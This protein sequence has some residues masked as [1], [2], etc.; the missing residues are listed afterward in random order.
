MGEINFKRVIAAKLEEAVERLSQALAAEGFGVLTRIEMHTTLRQ[1]LGEEIEPTVIL[2]ACNPQFALK[3]YRANS[4][5][6]SLLPCNAVLREVAPGR[7]SVEVAKPSA[8]LGPLAADAAVAEVAK[9]AEE[10]LARV[11]ASIAD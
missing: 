3:A 8:V 7:V 9:M 1:K 10:R 4:D 5:V 6:A 2:G 11:V